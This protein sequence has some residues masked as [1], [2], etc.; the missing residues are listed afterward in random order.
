[1]AVTLEDV[2][3]ALAAKT[4]AAPASAPTPS[5]PTAPGVTLADVQAALAKKQAP[6]PSPGWRAALR[7]PILAMQEGAKGLVFGTLGLPADLLNLYQQGM[8]YGLKKIGLDMAAPLT[9]PGGSEQLEKAYT[10][11]LPKLLGIAPPAQPETASER[12]VSRA[13]KLAGNVVGQ[14]ALTGAVRGVTPTAAALKREALAG[15]KAGAVG[16]TVQEVTDSPELGAVAEIGTALAPTAAAGVKALMRHTPPGKMLERNQA[17]ERLKE[18]ELT[19]GNEIAQGRD[20]MRAEVQA[21]TDARDEAASYAK[22]YRD[23]TRRLLRDSK[24]D[25]AAQTQ[26]LGEDHRAKITALDAEKRASQQVADAQLVAIQDR[27]VREIE[28]AKQFAVGVRKKTVENAREWVKA[29]PTPTDDEITKLYEKVGQHRFLLPTDLLQGAQEHIGEKVNM[30]RR[31]FPRANLGEVARL[32][33]LPEEAAGALPMQ[34]KVEM[35]RIELQKFIRT[36]FGIT[37]EGEELRGELLALTAPAE[38]RTTGLLNKGGMTL[39]EMAQAAEEA[40]YIL[41][42][43]KTALLNALDTSMRGRPVFSMHDDMADELG[44]FFDRA[45]GG[46]PLLPTE[47]SFQEAR[48]L[49]TWLG[50]RIGSLK[51]ATTPDAGEQLG[52]AKLLYQRVQQTLDRAVGTGDLSAQARKDLKAANAAYKVKATVDELADEI[53]AAI[54]IRSDFGVDFNPGKVLDTLRKGKDGEFLRERLRDVGLLDSTQTF[55]NR[56]GVQLSIAKQRVPAT[57]QALAKELQQIRAGAREQANT[58]AIKK[59]ELDEL[60]RL[61]KERIAQESVARETAITDQ[62][63]QMLDAIGQRQQQIQGAL[64]DTRQRFQVQKEGLQ[65][66]LAAARRDIPEPVRMPSLGFWGSGVGVAAWMNSV[67]GLAITAP[68]LFARLMMTAPGQRALA[69]MMQ[70]NNGAFSPE[71][72]QVLAAMVLR[73]AETTAPPRVE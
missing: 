57:R 63:Q 46:A 38:T 3:K 14:G 31:F 62:S 45:A 5:A 39:D 66:G 56:A 60:T 28:A 70:R 29:L 15:A 40:G 69:K 64:R 30:V 58:L 9:L 1:M 13:A 36:K 47:M 50:Q 42:P 25:E 4:Q 71:E 23:E 41:S 26:R 2:Q 7:L 11:R 54:S 55:L 67:P 18:K 8:H 12:V 35:P 68:V 53:E 21:L 73:D 59:G 16:G 24:A 52:A 19:I 20:V 65:E 17:L 44:D 48:A 33:A 37:A 43:D 51:R 27:K 6:V 10:E 22:Q 72:L 49:L 32:S 34:G 61:E